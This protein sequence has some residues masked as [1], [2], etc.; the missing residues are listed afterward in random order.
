MIRRITFMDVVVALLILICIGL[1]VVYF[2]IRKE[3]NL[4]QET[5][6]QKKQQTQNE[7]TS[8]SV[9]SQSD[10]PPES[11]HKE[12]ID[13]IESD[14]GTPLSRLSRLII[15]DESKRSTPYLD[16]EQTVTIGV[17]RSLS[18]NGISVNELFSII[19]EPDVRTIL[20]STE[21]K[22]G[23][24]YIKNFGVANQIFHTPLSEHDIELLL[25]DDLKNTTK[26]AM[27]VFGNTWQ[28]IT[29][30]RREAIIDVIFNLGLTRFRRFHKFID[31]VKAGEWKEAAIELHVSNEELSTRYYRN[32]M[33][34]QTGDAKYF[35][36][37]N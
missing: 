30:P 18:T 14:A 17:G 28:S 26:E 19:P 23:R 37:P 4:I 12:H 10:I 25:T 33:V 24:I 15:R 16:N 32:A 36:L 27:S 34:I 9:I 20:S 5:L 31:H 7:Q 35:E 11:P 1:T 3:Y 21:V 29:E 6:E 2:S 13:T 22:N 8:P